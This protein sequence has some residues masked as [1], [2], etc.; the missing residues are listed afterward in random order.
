MTDRI[1]V[2]DLV[3][4]VRGH[5]CGLRVRGGIPYRVNGFSDQ[6][7]GGWTCNLCGARDLAQSD[8]VAA[9]LWHT[10]PGAGIPLSWLKRIP[11]LSELEGVYEWEPTKFTE[12]A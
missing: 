7:G 12:P 1:Q 5:E 8:L 6:S 10:R 3:M 4:I 2:G 11:P 9:R